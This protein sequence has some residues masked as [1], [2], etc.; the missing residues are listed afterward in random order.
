MEKNS[1]T[2]ENILKKSHYGLNIYSHILR[3]EYP[4]DEI[5]MK[6]IGR[7]CGLCRNPFNNGSYTLKV[8]IE[9]LHPEQ[10]LC[11]EIARHHD[12][13]G[14]IPDGNALDFAARFYNLQDQQLLTHLNDSLHLNILRARSFYSK[15]LD[16]VGTPVIF[17]VF[18]AP[19]T[20]TK[21]FKETTLFGVYKYITGYYAQ[22]RTETL[23][24]MKDKKEARL[25]K[26]SK[27]DYCTFSGT[28][29]HRNDNALIEHSGLICLDFDHI[30][31]LQMT[32]E[33]LLN[34]KYFETQL[35]FRSPSGDG[36]KWIVCINIAELTHQEYF[37][38]ISNYIKSE[39]SLEVDKSGK[40]ISRACF[41]PYDPNAY[42]N[43]KLL[44]Q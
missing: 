1:L 33:K 24:S 30:Q 9:R 21:P 36:L 41:L 27:F 17:S 20:N 28:F 31:D 32:F 44:Q 37:K 16:E 5:I 7:D 22:E 19:V 3:N 26:A 4:D 39:Y 14:T 13:S 6:V 11:N 25:Y 40:D 8:W 23:R 12:I 10:E 18:K 15:P 35:L 43:P 38:A 42:I 34:D 2:R 29:K